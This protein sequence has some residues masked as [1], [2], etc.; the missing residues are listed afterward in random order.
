MGLSPSIVAAAAAERRPQVGFR[1]VGD[2]ARFMERTED[3]PDP[4]VSDIITRAPKIASPTS[5]ASRLCAQSKE[6]ETMAIAAVSEGALVGG[7]HPRDLL[8]A[9]TA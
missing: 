8:R 1:T 7:V 9:G 3:I 2:L 6:W 5:W 4:P